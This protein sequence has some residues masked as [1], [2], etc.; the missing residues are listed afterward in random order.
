MRERGQNKARDQNDRDEAA[1]GDL[2]VH[3]PRSHRIGQIDSL[4]RLTT[5]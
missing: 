4:T 3:S 2:A 5:S 1:Y